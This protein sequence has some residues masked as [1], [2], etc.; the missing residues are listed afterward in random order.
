MEEL[1]DC[2]NRLKEEIDNLNME[3]AATKEE[4][5]NFGDDTDRA[6][7]TLENTIAHLKERNDWQKKA[8]VGICSFGASR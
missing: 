6:I 7:T 5:K 1:N 3:L 2:K 4:R 8:K